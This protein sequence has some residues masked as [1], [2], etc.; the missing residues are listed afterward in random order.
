[1]YRFFPKGE[2]SI[3]CKTRIFLLLYSYV[4]LFF[5][6]LLFRVTLAAYGGSQA[7]GLIRATAVVLCQSHSNAESELHLCVL[8]LSSQQ[9][10]ILNPLSEARERT[11]NL[12]DTR[13]MHLHCPTMGTPHVSTFDPKKGN[14]TLLALFEGGGVAQSLG[15]SWS[16]FYQWAKWPC[17]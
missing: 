10:Q 1:M 9:C 17:F 2:T 13:W 11:H 12:M 5:F 14:T 4:F 15:N 7:R 8:H 3:M 6:F 16:M